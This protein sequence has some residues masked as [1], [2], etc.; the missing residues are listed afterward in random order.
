MTR[1]TGSTVAELGQRYGAGRTT[2]GFTGTPAAVADRMQE[3]QEAEACDG[4][5]LQIPYFPAPRR[6]DRL[7][8]THGTAGRG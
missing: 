2:I 3:W 6:N 1:R 4:F 7:T 5:M 8:R